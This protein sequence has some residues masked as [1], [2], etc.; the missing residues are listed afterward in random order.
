VSD[1]HD[2]IDRLVHEARLVGAGPLK[3]ALLEEAV[4]LADLH[5]DTAVGFQVRMDLMEAGNFA[6]RPDVLLVA[7][8]WC[9]AQHDRQPER[10]GVTELLWKY[11]WVISHLP[12]FPQISRAQIEDMLADMGRRFAQAGSTMHAVYHKRG[13]VHMMMGDQQAAA[14]AYAWMAR[15]PRD[16]LSDCRACVPDNEVEYLALM[17][18]DEEALARAAPLLAGRLTCAEV[19]QRT[20]A[21]VL[22]PL[23]RLGRS[24]DAM[25]CHRQGYRQVAGQAVFLRHVALHLVFLVLTDNLPKAVKVLEKHLPI[26][27]EVPSLS[28]R[29][30][31]LLAG[32]L[33]LEHVA[34]ERTQLKLHLPADFPLH[35]AKGTYVV[36]DLLGWFMAQGQDLA[37]RFDARNGNDYFAQKIAGLEKLRKW[38]TPCP[39]SA[40][41]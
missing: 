6:G 35:G 23:L 28:C 2:A 34:G 19:P 15:T 1:H 5:G 7:F 26:A 20:F 9:L 38:A 13:E 4:R 12:E 17:G 21:Q 40:R 16:S 41:E 36:A 32:R 14:E 3:V 25:H 37:A 31:F 39:L 22:L 10:F 11:K 33:L 18:R 27:L 24:P 8:S 29:F 30:E